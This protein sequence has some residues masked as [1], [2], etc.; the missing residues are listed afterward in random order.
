[1]ISFLLLYSN[2]ELSITSEFIYR[3]KTSSEL[4]GLCFIDVRRRMKSACTSHLCGYYI[5]DGHELGELKVNSDQHFWKL[6][7]FIVVCYFIQFTNIGYLLHS[8]EQRVSRKLG[9]GSYVGMGIKKIV[10]IYI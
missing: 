10:E 2:A 4:S 8:V 3:I 7:P 6:G 9:S 5:S 1:M